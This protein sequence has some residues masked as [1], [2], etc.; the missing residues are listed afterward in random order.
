MRKLVGGRIKMV[1]VGVGP[2]SGVLMADEKDI[3]YLRG[4]D[5]GSLTRIV[6]RHI[7]MFKPEKEPEGSASAYVLFCENKAARCPG[8]QFVV[9]G[10]GFRKADF[11]LFMGPCP[12]RRDDCR[13]GSKGEIRCVDPAFLAGMLDGTLYGGYPEKE[14]QG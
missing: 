8:V 1:V 9:S 14:A 5:D 6:K 2:V 7:A 12:C 13:H 4:D 3:V 10:E 11:D